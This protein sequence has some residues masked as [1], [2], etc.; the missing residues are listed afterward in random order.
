MGTL[1]NGTS[2]IPYEH[3]TAPGLDW[4]KA[5]RSDLDPI[6]KDCV[7]LAAAPP[8]VGHPHH[9]IPDGTRMVAISDD[10]DPKA[11]VLLMSRVE[12]SKFFDGVIAGEFD[13][14]R[15][16]AEELDAATSGATATA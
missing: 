8:A 7:I 10:K 6:V 3:Y 1:T 4:R 12:I 15:A 9:R 11:P 14:F 2:T 5:G 13:E 16:S